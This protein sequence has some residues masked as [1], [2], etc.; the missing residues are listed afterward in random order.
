MCLEIMYRSGVATAPCMPPATAVSCTS[1]PLTD[2]VT[3]VSLYIASIHFIAFSWSPNRS[4]LNFITSRDMRGNAPMASINSIQV[5][6]FCALRMPMILFSIIVASSASRPFIKPHCCTESRSCTKGIS[7]F[8]NIWS[9]IFCI[10][11][12]THIQR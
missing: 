8:I 7:R 12:H 2:A 10:T 4:R 6:W 3:F 9:M 11:W 5:C 1:F